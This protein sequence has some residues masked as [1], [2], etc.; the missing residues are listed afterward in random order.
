MKIR[1]AWVIAPW[2]WVIFYD[3]DWF[4]SA[5]EG[6]RQVSIIIGV[7]CTIF[8]IIPALFVKSRS[9]LDDSNLIP[10][11]LKYLSKLILV[12]KTKNQGLIQII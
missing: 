2:F 5:E 11:N 8:A 9:T 6:A 3:P 1:Y 12:M 7:I 4:N 10:L